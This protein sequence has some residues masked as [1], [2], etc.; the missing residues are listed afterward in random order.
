MTST[1][2]DDL[3]DLGCAGGGWERGR[4]RA[5]TL[6]TAR[7]TDKAVKA[8]GSITGNTGHLLLGIERLIEHAGKNVAVYLNTTV[9]R[10]YWSIGNHIIAEL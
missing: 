5:A 6:P 3:D 10:L 1:R 4:P 2:L 9:S 7:V 8:S